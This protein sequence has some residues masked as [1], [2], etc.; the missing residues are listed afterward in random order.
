[1]HHLWE[2]P[3]WKVCDLDLTFKGNPRSKIT[4][5]TKRSYMTLYLCLHTNIGHSI[6][7]FWDFG[8]ENNLK[9]DDSA[10]F[11][12]QSYITELCYLKF[13]P[14]L[15][16]IWYKTWKKTWKVDQKWNKVKFKSVQTLL[17]ITHLTHRKSYLVIICPNS[18]ESWQK[19]NYV[20]FKSVRT[21]L[22][23]THLAHRKS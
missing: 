14:N 16:I 17:R 12:T 22:R 23:I 7:R 4:R 13:Q 15:L 20:K 1:M 2:T 9:L 11:R 19:W 6:H 3:P 8:L 10:F 21:L 5:L 18:H